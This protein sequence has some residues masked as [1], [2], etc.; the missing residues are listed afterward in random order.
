M[1]L[2]LRLRSRPRRHPAARR[3]ASDWSSEVSSAYAL[4]GFLFVV[5]VLFTLLVM[6]PLIGIDASLNVHRPPKALLPVLHVLDRIGQRAVCLPVLAVVVYWIWRKAGRVRP[7]VVSVVS[8]LGVNFVVGVL[9]I[10]FGRGEPHMMDPNFFV[11]GM[12]YPSGHTANIMLVFGLIPYLLTSYAPIRRRT[13]RIWVGVVAVLSILM[14]TVSVTETWHWF[15]DLWAGL[16]I[17]G[18][19]LALTSAVDHSIPRDVFAHGIRPGLKQIPALLLRR[20]DA[21]RPGRSSSAP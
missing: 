3:P 19:V 12:A 5:F 8:V 14:V 6:G 13:F 4:A 21:P 17:G 11:G 18:V 1:S 7:A 20:R 16:M 15:A 9:K 2:D 10:G